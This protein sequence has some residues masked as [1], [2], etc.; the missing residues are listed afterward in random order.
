[1]PHHLRVEPIRVRLP[2]PEL[3]AYLLRG[4]GY[5]WVCSCGERG[6]RSASVALARAAGAEHRREAAAGE[7]SSPR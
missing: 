2:S 6:R 1:V 4:V 5:R 7:T 3:G